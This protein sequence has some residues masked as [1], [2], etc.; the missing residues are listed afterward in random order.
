MKT[1][2]Q[3]KKDVTNE[4]EWDPAINA[5][6][7]GVAVESGV[8]TLTGHLATYSEKH[9][10]EAAV[11]RV[12]GV[13]AIALE[14]DVKLEPQHQ[15]SDAEIAAAIETAFKWHAQIPED[16]L[17]VKVEKGWVTLSGEVDWDYERYNA[18]VAARAMTGVTGLV[19]S[20]AVRPRET[21]HY[22]A[23]RIH[24]ALVRYAEDEARGIEISVKDHTVTLSGTV[25][26]WA[27]RVAAQSAA[28]A[29]P[30]ISRVV[31]DLEVRA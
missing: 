25:N 15:R 6:H 1:D 29:A 27:E 5:T 8:V 10:V 24:D 19:S 26:S 14:I 11:R 21:P 9:A 28:W 31:D 20:I 22:V 4:L 3:L 18:E 7:V 2:A 12:A 16:R 17:Q 30:G 13:R 23:D